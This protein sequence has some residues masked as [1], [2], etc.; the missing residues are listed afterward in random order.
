MRNDYMYRGPV[1]QVGHHLDEL[2]ELEVRQSLRVVRLV[3]LQILCLASLSFRVVLVGFLG[4]LPSA[5]AN[6]L[7]FRILILPFSRK[8]I[9]LSLGRSDN[10]E[11]K[12]NPIKWHPLI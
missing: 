5:L 9:F 12:W 6:A 1:E 7:D 2:P 11:I 3:S 8:L 10:T 4:S